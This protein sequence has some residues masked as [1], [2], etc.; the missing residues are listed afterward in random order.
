MEQARHRPEAVGTSGIRIGGRTRR[1]IARTAMVLRARLRTLGLGGDVEIALGDQGLAARL[2]PAAAGRWAPGFDTTALRRQL[3]AGDADDAERE[4]LAA[5]LLAPGVIAF[6]DLGEFESALRI[7][8]AT[9]A[10]ARATALAFDCEESRPERCWV[11]TDDGT[12][13]LRPGCC[14]ISAIREATQPGPQ[15]APF[16]FGCYRATEY[17]LMLAIAQEAEHTHAALLEQLRRRFE[18]RPIQSREFHDAL[19]REYG[20]TE[21]PLPSRWFVPGD[22]VWFRN[23]DERS[24]DVEGYEGSWVIYK[25]NGLFSNFWQRGRPFTLTRKCVEIYHWRHAVVA[26]ADGRSRIDEDAVERRVADT[27]RDEAATR[28]IVERMQRLRDPR[29]V[30]ADGGCFDRTRESARWVRP[31][32]CDITLATG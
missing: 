12:F 15:A 10:A 32:T 1:E 3:A 7:R 13:A 4:T 18:R 28:A 23:P 17:V 31:G 20:T 27:L 11:R 5:L 19:L 29:G 9:V 6:P 2:R 25:G 22:R 16:A 30:Y 21:S 26:G 24:S 14:L 8:L